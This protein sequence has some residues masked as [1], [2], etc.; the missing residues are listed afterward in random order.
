M[1]KQNKEQNKDEKQK[2]TMARNN[3][4]QRI[5]KIVA[6]GVIVVFMLF[7]IVG[8][9]KAY[10]LRSSFIKPTQAQIDYATKIAKD[11]LQSIGGNLSAFQI[12]AGGRMRRVHDKEID[13][14][15]IQVLFYNNATSHTFLVDVNSG[16]ILLHSQTILH[17]QKGIY[18]PLGNEDKEGPHKKLGYPP[19]PP[20][21]FFGNSNDSSKK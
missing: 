16:E 6:I 4:K 13:R 20:P 17:S 11:K 2:Y 21:R 19:E 15:I 7:V 5:W 8:L 1:K 9:I 14:T 3:N 10:Y 12:Q 18:G